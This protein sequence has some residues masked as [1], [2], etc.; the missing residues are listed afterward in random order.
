MKLGRGL[1]FSWKRAAG[2]TMA[3]RKIARATGIPTHP[4]G[5]AGQGRALVQ[6]ALTIVATVAIEMHQTDHAGATNGA[7][8]GARMAMPGS[9]RT[10][11][12]VPPTA[13]QPTKAWTRPNPI[14]TR[15]VASTSMA[16]TPR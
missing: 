13:S 14:G 15:R 7:A 10:R 11:S 12:A 6:D 9:A 16:V 3:K 1:T 5:S 8:S 2:I 4:D